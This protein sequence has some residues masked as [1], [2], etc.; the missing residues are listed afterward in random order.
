MMDDGNYDPRGAKGGCLPVMLGAVLIWLA[1]A[2][3]F[4]AVATR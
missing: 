4:Y 2:A 3:I 1:I